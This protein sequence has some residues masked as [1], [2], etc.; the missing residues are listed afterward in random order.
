[1]SPAPAR[2]YLV[3][4]GA[5]PTRAEI[6]PQSRLPSSSRTASK[7]VLAT[8]PSLGAPQQVVTLLTARVRLDRLGELPVG[9]GGLGLRPGNAVLEP[10]P[11]PRVGVRA[12]AVGLHLPH[13][14]QLLNGDEAARR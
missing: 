6:L 12:Q 13:A 11:H 5:S 1:M 2:A 10:G 9:L 14:Q 8:V 7:V 3:G 4:V